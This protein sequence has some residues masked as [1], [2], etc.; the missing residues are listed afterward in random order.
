M[1]AFSLVLLGFYIL[2]FCA[3][4]ETSPQRFELIAA[5]ESGLEFRNDL[6]ANSQ[7][8]I[9][10]YL[11]FYNGG[12]VGVGDLTGDGLPEIYFSSNQGADE[13]YLNLGQ[14]RF[15]NASEALG[16]GHEEGWST[17]ISFV[18]INSDGRLDIYVSVAGPISGQEGATNRLYLNES[19]D[20]QLRLREAAAEFGL[21]QYGY[22]T[23]AAFFDY[24]QDGDLDC[25]QLNHSVHSLGT[26]QRRVTYQGT[27]HPLAG[28]RLLRN[29]GGN[30][31]DV[32]EAAGIKQ[33]A[34]GYGLG[35]SISD[36]NGDGWPDIYVGND[37]HED[38]YC[39]INQ[40]D[41]T[42]KDE[43]RKMLPH[44]SR[45]T[46]GTDIADLNNDGRPEIMSLDMLPYDPVVLKASAAEDPYDI[47]RM[48]KDQ[49]YW[50]QFSRNNLQFN[51]GVAPGDSLPVFADRAIQSGVYATDWSWSVL[52]EDFDQDGLR[53][54]FVANGILGRSNDMDYINYATEGEVQSRLKDQHIDPED[55]ALADRMPKIKLPN[56]MFR[57]LGEGRFAE[58]T[59]DWGFSPPTYSH[60]A[61][62]GDLDGDGDLDIVLNNVNDLIHLW[63]NKSQQLDTTEVLELRLVGNQDNRFAYGARVEILHEATVV[64]QTEMN[65]VRGFQSSVDPGKLIIPLSSLPAEIELSVY[66]PDGTLESFGRVEAGPL[67]VAAGTGQ[68]VEN[69][70]RIR[71]E[72]MMEFDLASRGMDYR[73]DENAYV[74][75]NREALMPHMVSRE[76]PAMASIF[77]GTDLYV[78][79]GGGKR[80]PAALY[81]VLY[82]PK[83]EKVAVPAFEADALSEDVDALVVDY[84][85]DG[86]DDLIVLSGGNE[87]PEKHEA[88]ELRFYQQTAAG[89]LIRD[90]EAVTEPVR[91]TG[92]RLAV[93]EDTDGP[94]Q[95]VVAARTLV[96]AYG[97]SPQSY[98]L[99]EAT[100]GR[101]SVAPL[102]IDWTAYGSSGMICDVRSADFDEDGFGD[103]VVATEWGPLLLIKGSEAGFK[104]VELLPAGN[105][106]WSSLL[107]GDLDD[108]D[109]LDIIAG[110]LGSNSKLSADADHLVRMYYADFDDNGKAE[111]L[112]TYTSS[113]G[114]RLFATREE[115]I[116]QLPGLRNIVANYTSFA[117]AELTELFSRRQ[118]DAAQQYQLD[119][120]KSVWLEQS[121]VGEWTVHELPEEL[122]SSPITLI[123]PPLLGDYQFFG[124][125]TDANIQR[126]Y[127]DASYGWAMDFEY[128]T[129]EGDGEIY[130]LY[131]PGNVRSAAFLSRPNDT[132]LISSLPQQYWLL[133]RNDDTPL[134]HYGR[135]PD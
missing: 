96:N 14:L 120:T 18:D 78:F 44:C 34:L 115:I 63:E 49:G 25:Y 90:L 121:A 103:L 117:N 100:T 61:A 39:Y 101:F 135:P 107:V 93:V 47:W 55:L 51:L 122:Q 45:F 8:N 7:Q 129:A 87:F 131:V 130:P 31:V 95:L 119:Q 104:E 64:Y 60:G 111:Q 105:G 116:A 97:A 73:H 40:G 94:L 112:I 32:S 125:R 77:M 79:L 38:D 16:E 109:D 92:S 58:V 6:S 19:A 43:L 2:G 128:F 27:E 28:D 24:D 83:F 88:N 99:T 29:E 76:G 9:F 12:G 62:Y 91:L 84:N 65:P 26:F 1:R 102:D 35:L 33:M 23:Q 108:D 22:G 10:N 89:E 114:E 82:G 42:F 110:N 21:D 72:S 126:G 4:G 75:F 66:W 37:F 50:P 133:G 127:Y 15:E 17:G 71:G 132:G 5:A 113:I 36:I 67:S 52:L 134:L 98:I 81:R 56:P 74:D 53:D 70:P 118:L 46:M 123:L 85:H 30:F 59:E 3:C 106:L 86:L 68:A 57:N 69:E 13:L 80:Q 11:Y 20:G 54:I 48:K 41:G 124:N